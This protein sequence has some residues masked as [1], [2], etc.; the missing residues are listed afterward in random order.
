MT[1]KP[2]VMIVDDTP[3]NLEVLEEI[4]RGQNYDVV[5][6]P[7]G[8]MALRAAEEN[9]PDIILLDIMMPQMNGFE[10]SKLW[11]AHEKLSEIPIIFVSALDDIE[12]KIKAFS[13]GGRDYIT[14]PFRHEEVCARVD[15][16]IK[17]S[18]AQLELKNNN[19]NL[20]AIVQ[21][22]VKEI[23]DSQMATLIAISSL[24][25]FRDDETGKHIHRTSVFCKTLAELLSVHPSYKN[26]IDLNFINNIFHAA[27]LHDIGK[28]G[29]PDRVLLKP[30]KLTSE[31]T[32]IMKTHVII[33]ATTLERVLEKY[34]NNAFIKMGVELTKSHHEKW[35]GSGYPFGLKG[36]AIPI[37]S[38][39]MALVDVYD[40]LRSKRSYKEA[41]NH[42]DTLY[43][44]K[45]EMENQFDPQIVEVFLENQFLFKKL[46]DQ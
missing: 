35:D 10:L 33:G 17:L 25:E 28:I 23:S 37:S 21:Q 44:I 27:P 41:I 22:K 38:R 8:H 11:M 39:I 16:Q 34:P 29:I 32:E 30:G 14:K 20:M 2:L 5:A 13:H 19:E 43:I 46:Y 18:R 45:V 12:H 4:L 9:P 15:T 6:F 1:R 36:E 24:A 31:E 3:A 26:T 42:E 40:A 7:R